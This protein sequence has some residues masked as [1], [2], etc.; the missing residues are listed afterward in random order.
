MNAIE[1]TV[2]RVRRRL[3]LV[4]GVGLCARFL[5]YG[6]GVAT[7]LLAADKLG[8]LILSDWR[9]A[10]L[11]PEHRLI[12]MGTVGI[13]LLAAGI[14]TLCAHIGI[15]EAALRLDAAM[16]LQERSAASLFIMS[17]DHPWRDAICSDASRR[18][19]GAD[20]SRLFPLPSA[21]VFRAGM[22]MAVLFL[23]VSL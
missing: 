15:R 3:R 12:V 5:P 16:G 7:A 6:L 14:L 19:E 21:G 4:R 10:V 13:A 2:I 20:V 22:G 8:V 1:R 18:L 23:G 17:T 11:P 9:S